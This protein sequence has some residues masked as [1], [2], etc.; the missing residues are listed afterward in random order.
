MVTKRRHGYVKS[1]RLFDRGAYL[2]VSLHRDVPALRAA[3]GDP[4]LLGLFSPSQHTGSVCSAGTLTPARRTFAGTMH[5]AATRLTPE[6]VA[7]ESIHA[8][9]HVWRMLKWSRATSE[10]ADLTVSIGDN[11]GPAEEEFALLVG[12]ITDGTLSLVAQL[13]DTPTAMTCAHPESYPQ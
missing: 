9:C 6:V 12:N 2:M 4:D 1:L 3:M 5:L 11:C 13:S 8:A 7:H 10:D